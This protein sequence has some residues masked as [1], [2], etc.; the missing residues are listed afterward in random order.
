V[1]TGTPGPRIGV[2]GFFGMGNIGNEGSLAA[3]LHGLRRCRPDLT[4]KGI[5]AAPDVVRS[6]HA[7]DAV[8]IMWHR[9]DPSAPVVT[10][11]VRKVLGR[12]ID[13]PRTWRALD[14]IDVLVVPGT[15]V[16]ETRLMARPWGMP[17]WLFITTA[18]CRLRRRPTVL[19]SVGAEPAGHPLT[20]L[21]FA[22]TARLA[23]RVS[24]RDESSRD[25]LRSWGIADAVSV[26]PDVA[27]ALPVP[28]RRATRP[29][30]VVVGVMTYEGHP[31]DPGRGP[32][33]V[34]EYASRMADAVGRL[35]STGHT[36]TL[37]VGDTADFTLAHGVRAAVLRADPS[38]G[39]QVHVSAAATLEELVA[40]M[41]QAEVAVASRFHNLV[42]ALLAGTP[43]VSLSYADKNG[44]LLAKMGLD[45]L[46]QP[47]ESFDVDVLLA[48]LER[49]RALQ[50]A[51]DRAVSE[52]VGQYA[53]DLA[54]EFAR[55]C[56]EEVGERRRGPA[57]R[58]RGRPPRRAVLLP[59]RR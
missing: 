35:A 45:G 28:E 46:D 42:G 7:I 17:Y 52:L 23:T 36:V 50:P 21:L 10:E 57:G 55:I 43:A 58:S 54:A 26:T 13:I 15:G 41:M 19:L 1:S 31:D 37:V 29:G 51:V 27:F 56:H 3:A 40:E 48:H 25:V 30:H 22:G 49:A 20:R 32:H 8:Q 34:R 2:F 33:V 59:G 9:G 5:V 12:L 4:F 24:V 38:L 39:D 18:L 53:D 6:D 16:L 14:D 11:T 47:L 44:R